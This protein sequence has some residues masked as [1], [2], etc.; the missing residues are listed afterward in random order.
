MTLI[1]D[2]RGQPRFVFD[3]FNSD[4]YIFYHHWVEVFEVFF[5]SDI[6]ECV[7]WFNCCFLMSERT[8]L[9]EQLTC[10]YRL[11]IYIHCCS[12]HPFSFN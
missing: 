10:K 12:A 5:V 4:M 2:F 11:N 8:F 1:N 6:F 7:C 3:S 9:S